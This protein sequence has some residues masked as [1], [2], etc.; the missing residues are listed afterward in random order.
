MLLGHL[1]VFALVQLVLGSG[2][3][4]SIGLVTIKEGLETLPE[5][6]AMALGFNG[7]PIIATLAY[8]AIIIAANV[9]AWRMKPSSAS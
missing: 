2:H 7:F 9:F 6:A 1:A 8:W 5:A 4:Q 3:D